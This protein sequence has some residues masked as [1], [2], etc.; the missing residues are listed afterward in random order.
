MVYF[1]T[2]FAAYSANE[3]NYTFGVSAAALTRNTNRGP[4]VIETLATS[5][6][7]SLFAVAA[8]PPL[9]NDSSTVPELAVLSFESVVVH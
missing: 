2:D 3:S 1:G 8:L 7:V 5:S 6:L 9:T 4:D